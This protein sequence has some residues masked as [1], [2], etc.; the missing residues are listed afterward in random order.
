MDTVNTVAIEASPSLLSAREISRA[1]EYLNSTRDALLAAVTGLDASQWDFKPMPVQW[2]IAEILEH[3]AIVE[4]R[5]HSLIGRMK[6]APPAEAGRNDAQ[7]DEFVIAAV[8]QRSTKFEAPP[9]ILPSHQWTP[10]ETLERF[11]GSRAHTIHLLLNA[12]FLRGHVAPHPVFGPWDGYQWILAAA[13]HAARHTEQI[14]E[15]KGCIGFPAA[16]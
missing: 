7:I 12:P 2:S 11:T 14:Q 9:Q 8:P 16:G 6:D 5:V 1:T 3:I 15:V 4:N 13:G 10:A